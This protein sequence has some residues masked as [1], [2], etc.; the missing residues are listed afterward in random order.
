MKQYVILPAHILASTEWGEAKQIHD[1]PEKAIEEARLVSL[2][3]DGEPVL[4]CLVVGSGSYGGWKYKERRLSED[5]KGI[6]QNEKQ[7]NIQP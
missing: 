7:R 5:E 4:V 1:T 2:D 3:N 6:M